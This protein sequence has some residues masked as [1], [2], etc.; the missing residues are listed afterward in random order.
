MEHG[1]GDM[2]E[3]LSATPRRPVPKMVKR[4][5]LIVSCAMAI[6]VVAAIIVWNNPT[7]LYVVATAM[8]RWSCGLHIEQFEVRS[9][10]TPTLV[11]GP[12]PS[13]GATLGDGTPILFLHGWGTSKESML[14]QM[15][16]FSTN[17]RVI[18]PD[19]PGFGDNPLPAEWHALTGLGYVRWIEDFRVA[20]KLGR[21]DIVGESMGGAFA[22]AYAAE[23]PDSVR[24]IALQAPAG[25]VAPRV[26][27]FMRE[28]A[29]GENPLR[30]TNEAEM[31]R[32]I[33]LCFQRPPPV[34]TAFKTYL[35]NRAVSRAPRQQEMIDTI[36][37]FL[38]RGNT[39]TL[40]LI[41]APTLVMYGSDDQI[42]D[43]SLLDVYCNGIEHSTGVL[44]PDAGHVI[45]SDA[46]QMTR[47]VLSEFLGV[48]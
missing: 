27:E 15:G 42:T 46:P 47:T 20:A 2:I 4:W 16:W 35:I 5:M 32:V 38:M 6:L 21:I 19:L 33:G 7:A 14:I 22:A 8:G 34:P 18:A 17:R 29:A 31:D 9:V 25:L 45:F 36:R 23:Y 26:N 10:A 13:T 28:V 44:I 24:R 39:E 41:R 11:G 40:H 30:I 48:Q 12:S 37:E 1:K 43:P 3:Q